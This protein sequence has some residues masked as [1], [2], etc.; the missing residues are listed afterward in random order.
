[1]DR[2]R[3][4]GWIGLVFCVGAIIWIFQGV[5]IAIF[6]VFGGIFAFQKTVIKHQTLSK[7]EL[8]VVSILIFV[9]ILLPLMFMP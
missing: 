7:K 9:G 8:R 5:F 6:A 2:D 4:I 3:T 1:M